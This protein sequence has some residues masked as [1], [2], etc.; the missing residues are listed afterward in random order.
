MKKLL[1]L[2]ALLM[3]PLS[4]GCEFTRIPPGSVGILFDGKTGLSKHITTPALTWVG[5]WQQMI[6]FPVSNRS[7]VYV[8]KGREGEREGDDAIRITTSEGAVLPIDVTVVYRIEKKNVSDACDH[9]GTEDLDAVQRDYIR[10]LTI[11]ALNVASGKHSI[12][13]LTSSDRSNLPKEVKAVLAPMMDSLDITVSDVLIRTTHTP[14]DIQNKINEALRAASDLGTTRTNLEKAKIEARTIITQA[15]TQAA[16]NKL[17]GS[18]GDKALELMDRQIQ[19]QLITNWD[20]LNWE[21]ND[22]RIPFTHQRP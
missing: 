14:Q 3:L 2:T 13:E 12:F 16:Q 21:V 10:P 8:M 18:Q 22:G 20:G 17:L 5:P 19:D 11:Y 1:A 6:V 4:S 15:E 7:A 9:L